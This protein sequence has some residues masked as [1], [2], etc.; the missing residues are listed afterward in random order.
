MFIIF[1]IE[2]YTFICRFTEVS[3]ILEYQKRTEL[4]FEIN[5]E[6]GIN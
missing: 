5:R 3:I 2:W 6:R 1:D 4:S